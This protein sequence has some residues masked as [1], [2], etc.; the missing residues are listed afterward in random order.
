MC[1]GTNAFSAPCIPHE[2]AG[3]P[4]IL[5]PEANVEKVPTIFRDQAFIAELSFASTLRIS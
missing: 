4:D 3:H 5:N 2:L 1:Q